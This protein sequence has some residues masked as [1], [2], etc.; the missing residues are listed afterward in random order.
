[1][2]SHDKTG[3]TGISSICNKQQKQVVLLLERDAYSLCEDCCYL[4]DQQK[5]TGEEQELMASEDSHCKR[6]WAYLSVQLVDA[7][8]LRGFVCRGGSFL[9]IR[10]R[11][12][13]L[14]DDLRCIL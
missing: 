5:K 3:C 4:R 11:Y 9:I 8:A 6:I 7:T 2:K 1:M 12:G 14:L 10:S 13:S